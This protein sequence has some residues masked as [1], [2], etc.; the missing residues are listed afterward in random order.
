MILILLSTTIISFSQVELAGFKLG[1]VYSE[2]GSQTTIGGVDGFIGFGKIKDGRVSHIIFFPSDNHIDI[3]KIYHSDIDRIVADLEEK[4][5]ITFRKQKNG[6]DGADY[7]LLAKSP[8]A[9]Y[10]CNVK[11]DYFSDSPCSFS[12]V[13]TNDELQKIYDKEKQE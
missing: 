9:S 6:N 2:N 10:R 7:Y 5:S 13:I 4:F 1:E 12:L 8:G 11:G 3:I